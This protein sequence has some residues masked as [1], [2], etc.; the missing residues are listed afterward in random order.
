M[1]SILDDLCAA[2]NTFSITN[3]QDEFQSDL[4]IIM[5]KMNGVQIEDTNQNWLVLK[6]NYTKLNYLLRCIKSCS[7]G[8]SDKFSQVLEKFIESIDRKTQEYIEEI[9][10]FDIDR[11][12]LVIKELLLESLNQ[13]DPVSK[14]TKILEAYHILIPIVENLRGE[15]YVF[16]PM[17]LEELAPPPKRQ[18][19]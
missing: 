5:N 6:T 18:K 4:D 7:F 2:V 11:D 14:M 17:F 12:E 3:A 9:D 13:N 19:N 15:K 16:D 1:D 10:F 8:L